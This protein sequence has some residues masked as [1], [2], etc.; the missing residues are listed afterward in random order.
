VPI[1]V[2]GQGA[3][4]SAPVMVVDTLPNPK[5]AKELPGDR[6]DVAHRPVE[7]RLIGLRRSV[8]AADLPDELQGG[9]VELRI[10]RSVI[11]VAEPFDVSTHSVILLG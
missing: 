4:T 1:S 3:L 10:R 11:G 6:R 7:R 5:G 9:I 8:K 2:G